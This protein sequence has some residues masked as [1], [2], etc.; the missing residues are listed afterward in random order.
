M[1]DFKKPVAD[2]GSKGKTVIV[3][4][5]Y[6]RKDKFPACSIC[7]RTN[8]LEKDCWYKEKPHIECR[9]CKKLGH[10]ERNC[11]IKQ[12]QVQGRYQPKDQSTQ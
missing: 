11:R 2:K 7:Q 5:E 1:R 12:N 4:K 10:I 8:H 9:F 3:Q 6:E